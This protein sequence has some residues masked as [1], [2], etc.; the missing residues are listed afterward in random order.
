MAAHGPTGND[1]LEART[2]L[3]LEINE[4][5]ERGDST[6]FNKIVLAHRKR[7]MGT[8]SRIILVSSSQQSRQIVKSAQNGRKTRRNKFTEEP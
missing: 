7:L 2:K 6:A 3:G 4:G 5:A 8:V 1:K